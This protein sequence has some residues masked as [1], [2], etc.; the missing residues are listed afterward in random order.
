MGFKIT[1][2]NYQNILLSILIISGAIKPFFI[3]YDFNID[4]TLVVLTLICLDIIS[5]VLKGNTKIRLDQN[6]IFLLLFLALFYGWAIFS[7]I[8]SYSLNYSSEK[9][10]F[11]LIPIL[12]FIYPIFI[13]EINLLILYKT[14]IYIVLPV[15]LWFILFRF[16]LYSN[17]D[18]PLFSI[19]KLRFYNLRREYLNLGYL[20]GILIFLSIRYSKKSTLVIVIS[21]AIL[22]GLGSRGALLFVLISLV[23]VYYPNIISNIHDLKIGKGLLK[24]V[25]ATF[26]GTI[27]L[28]L[29]FYNRIIY[30]INY[31][32]ARFESIFSFGEDSSAMERITP[33]KFAFEK[34][35]TWE[36][37]LFGY[38]IGS[39]GVFYFGEDV[40][41]YPHN[42][43][44]ESWF[45]LGLAGLFFL[46]VIFFAPLSLHR[47]K[48]FKVMALFALLNSMK[49]S[50]FAYD[51]NLF[52]LFGLLVFFKNK[53][54]QKKIFNNLK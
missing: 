22:L 31:G 46:T 35:M 39:W 10:L 25:I 1:H 26:I 29:L 51:R 6:Q 9:S 49:S 11:M 32:L 40:M 18:I 37:C 42:I 54:F 20:I 13:K 8:Y 50:S 53:P 41:G 12:G 3:Y 43:F 15:S 28:I 27:F 4:I 23:L 48:I 19:D 47:E 34:I 7:N 14:L 36:G 24:K 21:I 5:I 16:L 2:S 17:N 38:G 52:I 30:F 45:E 33:Y 44:I